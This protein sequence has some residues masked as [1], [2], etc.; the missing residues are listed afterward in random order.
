MATK[1]LVSV[2]RLGFEVE[3]TAA[4]G[5]KAYQAPDLFAIG[6]AIKLVQGNQY[7]ATYRDVTNSGYTYWSSL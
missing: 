4:A 5:R 1:N 6:S 7:I 2:E 3:Q